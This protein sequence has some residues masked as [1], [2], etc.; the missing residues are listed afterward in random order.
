MRYGSTQDAVAVFSNRELLFEPGAAYTYSSYG[1][2]LL[3]AA[4]EEAA[5][6]PFLDYVKSNI[7]KNITITPDALLFGAPNASL[8]YEFEN[9]AAVL[10]APHDYSYSWGGAGFSA[11]AVG[12]ARFG[13]RFITGQV[14]NDSTLEM[15]LTP[16][17]FNDG[18]VVRDR[19]YDVGFGWRISRDGNGAAYAHHAGVAIGARSALVVIPG[20]NIG[21]AILS[22]AAWT[23]SIEQTALTLALPFRTDA[24][25]QEACP[26]GNYQYEG[27]FDGEAISG[28]ISFALDNGVC[29]G[30]VSVVNAFR[31]M[32]APV[33]AE[34][35][36][37]S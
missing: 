37:Y 30:A 29:T 23:S 27:D 9:G 13:S 8:A 24:S 14:V 19:N 1:Y 17:R 11:T 15:M 4:I 32:V 33:S 10:S 21:A 25:I 26:T 7:T 36:G 6:V 18:R 2:T 20:E 31:G 28:T 22:N 12:L 35:C 3:S 5:G 34:R 16:A